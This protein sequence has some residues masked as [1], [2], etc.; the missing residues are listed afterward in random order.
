MPHSPLAAAWFHIHA[1]QSHLNPDE[2]NTDWGSE[3][4]F[5][6]A[7]PGIYNCGNLEAGG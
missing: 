5:I 6:A 7:I 2:F 4:A 1:D 3:R